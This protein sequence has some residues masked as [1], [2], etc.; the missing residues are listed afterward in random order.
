MKNVSIAF[1]LLLLLLGAA[2]PPQAAADTLAVDV[3]ITYQQLISGRWEYDF[4]I[5]NSSFTVGQSAATVDAFT[6][7]FTAGSYDNL[8][9]TNPPAQAGWDP[10]VFQPYYVVEG[11]QVVL[12]QDGMYD[13][14][15]S[16]GTGIAQ[17]LSE[18]GFKVS[19]DWLGTGSP[20]EALYFEVYHPEDF[21]QLFAGMTSQ[22]LVG[23]TV[24][25]PPTVLLLGSGA[26]SMLVM[27]RFRRKM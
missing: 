23:T 21:S 6:V 20:S 13:A 25:L 26:V 8:T 27:R 2:G 12:A 22:P 14:W 9:L 17:G 7:Y 11:G 1:I 18:S 15:K 24:P 16:A 19:F 5:T 4:T 3:G 10:R